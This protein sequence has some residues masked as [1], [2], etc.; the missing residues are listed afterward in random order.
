[1]APHWLVLLTVALMILG[2]AL[3]RTVALAV[4]RSSRTLHRSYI[5]S[6]ARDVAGE[7]LILRERDEVRSARR[8]R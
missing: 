7:I 5:G 3:L 4:I 8:K 6:L 2:R 1:M